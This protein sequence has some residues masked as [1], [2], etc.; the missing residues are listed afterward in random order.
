MKLSRFIALSTALVLSPTVFAS[1][2]IQGTQGKIKQSTKVSVKDWTQLFDSLKHNC[3]FQIDLNDDMSLVVPNRSNVVSTK[4][5]GSLDNYMATMYVKNVKVFGSDVNQITYGNNGER[6]VMVLGFN[7]ANFM[8]QLP[9]F[10]YTT[11]DGVRVSASATPKTIKKGIYVY[12]LM[13]NGYSYRGSENGN[14]WYS[15]MLF[16]ENKKTISCSYGHHF[17]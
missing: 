4:V 5:N 6:L 14:A 2:A 1:P 8:K 11:P 10:S 3:D 7:D 17:S 15:S 9:K 16:D 13:P 12:N